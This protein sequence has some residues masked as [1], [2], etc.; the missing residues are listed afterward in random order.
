MIQPRS[1]LFLFFQIKT[2]MNLY[3]ET[4]MNFRANH[5][6]SSPGLNPV[7]SLGSPRPRHPSYLGEEL[8]RPSPS[9]TASSHPLANAAA[10]PLRQKLS[11]PSFL[12]SPSRLLQQLPASPASLFLSPLIKRTEQDQSRHSPSAVLNTDDDTTMM[13]QV[14]HYFIRRRQYLQHNIDISM[15]ISRWILEHVIFYSVETLR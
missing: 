11:F 13:E 9:D 15:N 10:S 5:S 8:A 1:T 3:P 6:S 4:S 2:K 7:P 12:P 14:D